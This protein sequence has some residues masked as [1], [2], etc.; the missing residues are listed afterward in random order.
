MNVGAP[1]H[2]ASRGRAF[3]GAGFFAGEKRT[4]RRRSPSA[5]PFVRGAVGLAP[6]AAQLAVFEIR[7]SRRLAAPNPLPFSRGPLNSHETRKNKFPNVSAGLGTRAMT[8]MSAAAPFSVLS[9]PPPGPFARHKSEGGPNRLPFSRSPLNSHKS[10]Q[11]RLP[12]VSAGPWTRATRRDRGAMTATGSG[13]PF[14]FFRGRPL[15]GRFARREAEGAPRGANRLPFSRRPLNSRESRKN[16]F[17][18]V[19]AGLRRTP[20]PGRPGA[21]AANEAGATVRRRAMAPT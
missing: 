19:S 11:N 18:N 9:H 6:C 7:T 3:E 13:A 14:G 12:N 20:A 2:R 8:A 1:H 21:G 17:P 10:R 15:S 4:A 5:I 16:K